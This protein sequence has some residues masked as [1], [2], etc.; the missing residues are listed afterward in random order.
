MRTRLLGVFSRICLTGFW[1]I[2]ANST[3]KGCTRSSGRRDTATR[4]FQTSTGKP[5]CCCLFH[6][7]FE[8]FEGT[9]L[10][11][12]SSSL[13]PPPSLAVGSEDEGITQ[14]VLI[15][16]HFWTWS[17]LSDPR[18]FSQKP[19]LLVI[20]L[21][22]ARLTTLSLPLPPPAL[23]ARR[24]GNEAGDVARIFVSVSLYLYKI[25]GLPRAQTLSRSYSNF[26]R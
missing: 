10:P 16:I 19:V 25:R 23:T 6:A 24:T 26:D 3:K 20:C 8:G 11:P 14:S 21:V 12:S 1:S 7:R 5:T 4:S 2:C 22:T 17:A 13:P 9:P 18:A 15:R